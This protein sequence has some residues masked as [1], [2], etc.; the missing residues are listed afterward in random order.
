MIHLTSPGNPDE[1]RLHRFTSHLFGTA[2]KNCRRVSMLMLDT[3]TTG[4][5]PGLSQVIELGMV[6][7]TW[8]QLAPK[9]WVLEDVLEYPSMLQQP[10]KPIPPES[11]AVHG[12]RD[13]DVAGHNIDWPYVVSVMQEADLVVAFNAGFDRPILH[14]EFVARQTRIPI[15]PWAC[16]LEMI[17]WNDMPSK[18][19]A[20]NLGVLAAWHG[21]FFVAHRAVMDCHAALHLLNVSG[22]AWHLLE[23]IGSDHYYV[24]CPKRTL[25]FSTTTNDKLKA[26]GFRWNPDKEGWGYVARTTKD[27]QEKIDFLQAEVYGDQIGQVQTHTI[28]PTQR[29]L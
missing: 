28:A 27:M 8:A 4:T 7:S 29:F 17:P 12:I 9:T 24:F 10:D 16:A 26:Q 22:T 25:R 11:I 3:E 2:P 20:R 23:T 13:E 6:K 19:P 15:V 14:A 21:F 5:T 18:A 1:V